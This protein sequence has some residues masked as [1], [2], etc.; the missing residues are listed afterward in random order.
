VSEA[1]AAAAAQAAAGPASAAAQD[2]RGCTEDCHAHGLHGQ[3]GFAAGLLGDSSSRCASP[4][5][6]NLQQLF[7]QT[8]CEQPAPISTAQDSA[9]PAARMQ[10]TAP[11]AAAAPEAGGRMLHTA[12]AQPPT[13]GPAG[14]GD[15]QGQQAAG[16]GRSR[17]GISRFGAEEERHKQMKV[18]CF[19]PSS[20]GSLHPSS[21]SICE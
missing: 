16:R 9:G 6:D 18:G 13:P 21:S 2:T 14:W 3:A 4:T 12:H 8:M 19:M 17:T 10:H 1:A 15:L 7:D 11:E 20:C 5:A